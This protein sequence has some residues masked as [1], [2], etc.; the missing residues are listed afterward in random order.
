M[1]WNIYFFIW[2]DNKSKREEDEIF[3]INKLI[4]KLLEVLGI[5]III[6]I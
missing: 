1:F 2:S 5:I 3:I 4:L 6:I